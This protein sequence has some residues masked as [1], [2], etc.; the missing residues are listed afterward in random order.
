MAKNA[1]FANKMK[2]HY[3]NYFLALY[4]VLFAKSVQFQLNKFFSNGH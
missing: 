1:N 2:V 4:T 3:F